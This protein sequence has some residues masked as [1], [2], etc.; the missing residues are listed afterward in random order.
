MLFFS[1]FIPLIVPIIGVLK[2]EVCYNLDFYQ[3]KLVSDYSVW[4]IKQFTYVRTD[5][6]WNM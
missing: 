4:K 3:G 6:S 1:S 5:F 2:N